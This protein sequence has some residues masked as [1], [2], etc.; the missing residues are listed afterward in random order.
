MDAV[1]VL[2][3]A[4]KTLTE[5]NDRLKKQNQSLDSKRLRSGEKNKKLTA[6]L[7]TTTA[8][9]YNIRDYIELALRVIDKKAL[10]ELE[11]TDDDAR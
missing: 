10:T 7:T 4:I 9:L 1:D 5:E 11:A 6:K 8:A 3:V 2:N